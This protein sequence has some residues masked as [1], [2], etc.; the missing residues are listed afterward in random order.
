VTEQHL[1]KYTREFGPVA[2]TLGW[3][4]PIRYLLRRDRILRTVNQLP[5]GN[6]LEIGC[7]AGALADEFARAGWNVLGIESS[8]SAYAMACSLRQASG[9][10]QK[11]TMRFEDAIGKHWD[12]L[13]AFD[14]LEHIEEDDQALASWTNLLPNGGHILIS[15][16][17][18]SKRW[19]SGDEWAGH[20]R[21]YDRDALIALLFNK[22]LVPV[23]FE[24][25]GFPLANLTEYV[26]AFFY[27]KLIQNR[28]TSTT[29][30]AATANSGIE[31]RI[32][33]RYFGLVTSPIGRIMLQLALQAQNLTAKREWGSG[34]LVLAK[35][36]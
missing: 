12:L 1:L 19:N 16:P 25:Y 23:H 6:C 7:G 8:E 14:V 10:T 36:K 35:K 33:S 2:S 9:G 30:A 18:H 32:A 5:V 31:R 34:Y 22:N 3:T 20:Y 13:C 15:V 11:L 26:G 24:C 17:A 4:P 21:R 27:R 28:A 29:K